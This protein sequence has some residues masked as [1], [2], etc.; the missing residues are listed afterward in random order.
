M[1]NRTGAKLA[2]L[3]ACALLALPVSARSEQLTLEEC[4]ARAVAT[5][6]DLVSAL[7]D[8]ESDTAKISQ[9]ASGSRTQF[10]IS[11]SYRRSGSSTSGYDSSTGSWS[12]GINASQLLY[13]FGKIKTAIKSARL[14]KDATQ[15]TAQRTLETVVSDVKTAYYSLNKATRDVEVV[16]EQ[17]D[18]YSKRLDWAKSY[19]SVG[20]KAKIEV[21]KAETDLA[22]SKLDLI[23]A[24]SAVRL[25]Q[26]QLASAMGD[27]AAVELEVADLLDFEKWEISLE[28]A[29]SAAAENRP[30]LKAQD[31]QT[32]KAKEDI[33]SAKLNSAPSISASA[34]YGSNGA[35]AF[36][37]DEWSASISLEFQ[38]GDGGYT[39]ARIRQAEA[40]LKSQEAKREKL[41]QDI[42]LEVRT[43][44]LELREAEEAIVASRET[45]RQAKENLDLAL[46]RY[47]AGV[48]DS[49]EVSDAVNEYA[50]ARSSVISCLYDHKA[51]K[52]DLLEAMGE[53]EL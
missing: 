27:S 8:V 46:G 28:D 9:E 2:V 14:T 38:F 26:A 37:S 4:V 7:A 30:D 51:A 52:T 10:G 22:N 25:A 31:L 1:K 5:H 23:K 47:R 29:L 50:E 12:T 41:A 17:Y 43:A 16:K 18:N 35:S 44:W 53:V 40:D 39:K 33:K 15:Q 34:G 13:D 21:T 49:L 36:D 6:P 19:Y 32:E 45:E 48:G 20:T 24:Y 3:A 42:I 11:G